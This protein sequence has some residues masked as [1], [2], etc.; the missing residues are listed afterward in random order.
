[1]CAVDTQDNVDGASMFLYFLLWAVGDELDDNCLSLDATGKRV[2]NQ[3]S[4][5]KNN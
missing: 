3:E 1:M 5:N 2:S 4:I